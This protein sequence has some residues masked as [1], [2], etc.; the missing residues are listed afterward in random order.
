MNDQS[1]TDLSDFQPLSPAEERLVQE[2]SDSARITLTGGE[3][4]EA[5]TPETHVRAEFIRHV[6]VSDTIKLTAKGLRLR[7]AWITGVLDLQGADI[8]HD[9]SLSYCVIDSGIELVN[10]RMRG[11]YLSGCQMRSLSGDNAD[12]D[13][14]LFIRGGTVVDG[15]V[16]LA[17]ARISGDLQGAEVA[18]FRDEPDEPGASYPIRLDGFRYNDFS[19]H[20]DTTVATRLNWLER[21][22]TDTPFT[23]QPYE[24]LARVLIDMGHRNDARAVLMSKER[25]LRQANRDL[26]VQNSGYTPRWAIARFGDMVLRFSVGYGYRPGRII[27]LAVVL[28]AALGWIFD[29]TWN[30]GDM[31]PN[32]AP[33][34]VSK[35]WI[36]ATQSHPENPGAFWSQPDQAGKDWETFNAYAY[37]ADLV[38]PIVSLGQESAWAP[39]TSRS[40]W[41]RFGWWLRW[42]AKALGWVITA[43]GA[44]AV[45]GAVRQE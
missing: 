15:D 39:S 32:A 14:A 7:G 41:G 17:G 11:L 21:R 3:L 34:L 19:R 6:L 40:D 23:A 9:L 8:P 1:M 24:Q 42:I 20:A 43:L 10:A 2:C 36:A 5:E 26:M 38:V 37:A 4:P 44:A 29:Q 13:G 35:D 33:I 22:P 31:T 18:R 16:S 30:A 28:I 25:L 27:V 45:T 12:L